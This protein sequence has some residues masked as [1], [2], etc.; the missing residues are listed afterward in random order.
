M[1]A[2]TPRSSSAGFVLI[3]LLVALSVVAV[4]AGLMAGVFGQLRSVANLREQMV[5]KSEL[6]G[7]LSHLERT[8]AGTRMA[9]LPDN[10]NEQNRMFDGT[11]SS[12]RFAA[13]TRQGFYS[14]ALRDIDIH[15]DRGGEAP[16]LVQSM[17]LRRPKDEVPEA[18]T[19]IIL[20]DFDSLAFAYSDDGKTFTSSFNKDGALPM[21][22]RITLSR[23]V[24]GKQVTAT[25][26]A[27]VL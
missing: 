3:E 6:E 25:T 15:I 19:I 23:T 4:M 24:M 22:V 8:L 16:R 2:G 27:R 5:V 7:T 12:M 13:V 14:L 18:Q 9:K 17:S 21:L 10:E 1:T 20:D 26:V 11:A